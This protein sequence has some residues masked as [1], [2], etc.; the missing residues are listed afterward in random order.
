MSTYCLEFI[1]LLLLSL[2]FK[3]VIR[4]FCSTLGVHVKSS[5]F[6][7]GFFSTDCGGKISSLGSFSLNALQFALTRTKVAS[8]LLFLIK[9]IMGGGRV[10]IFVLD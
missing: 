9:F 5:G 6:P 8:T 7:I 1:V 4:C 10:L 2:H 3:S